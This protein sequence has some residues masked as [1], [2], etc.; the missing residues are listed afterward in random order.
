MRPEMY[1]EKGRTHTKIALLIPT[2][3]TYS[4]TTVT[5]VT[6]PTITA[7]INSTLFFMLLWYCFKTNKY[8]RKSIWA[9]KRILASA[10]NNKDVCDDVF[11]N[12]VHLI[13]WLCASDSCDG[14]A[15]AE[16]AVAIADIAETHF[17][18]K[19]KFGYSATGFALARARLFSTVCL[20]GL[21]S[22]T[23]RRML[24][25]SKLRRA[26]C[27]SLQFPKVGTE[28]HQACQ[29]NPCEN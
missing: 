25:R 15:A 6:I 23:E 13:R 7:I 18:K 22:E 28:S 10:G 16:A 11:C 24:F 19:W 26:G 14:L 21:S 9:A 12:T 20:S 27:A 8:A 4:A 29:R 5:T 1:P 2:I 3:A 17:P